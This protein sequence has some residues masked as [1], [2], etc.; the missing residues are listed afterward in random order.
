MGLGKK[1]FLIV[2]CNIAVTLFVA[3]MGLWEVRQLEHDI[4]SILTTSHSLRNHME[5]DMMHDALRGDVLRA[6]YLSSSKD[7]RIGNQKEVLADI[8]EHSDH[9]KEMIALNQTLDLSTSTRAKLTAT[10]TALNTYIASA[11]RIATVAFQDY[12]TAIELLPQFNSAFSDLEEK[13]GALSDDLTNDG[14]FAESGSE[15]TV[16]RAN[17]AMPIA[18]AIA[19]FIGVVFLFLTNKTVTAV[20]KSVSARMESLSS[21]LF[22]SSDQVSASAQSLA[23]GASEQAASLQETAATVEQVSSMAKHNAANAQQANILSLTVTNSSQQGVH[24]MKEMRTAIDAIQA[25]SDETA[26]IIRTID[27]IAFQ[28]NLLAL[29]AAVEAA[30]AGEAGKGFAVVAEEVR[31]LA[32]RSAAAA[33]ETSA[34]IQRSKELSENGVRVSLAVEKS[35][36]EIRANSTKALDIVKEIAAASDE[37][38]TGLGQL[39]IAM[40]E[41]DKVTQTNAA[42]AEQSSAAGVELADQA[43]LLNNAVLAL[44]QIIQGQANPATTSSATSHQ[45]TKRISS[46]SGKFAAPPRRT[47]SVQTPMRTI[48]ASRGSQKVVPVGED[49]FQMN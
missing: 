5:G 40:S 42:S 28:T 32:Q 22:S 30:R 39:N 38:S 20:L 9:F 21:Q 23:Q 16:A 49:D 45:A 27:E 43:H 6:L 13:L 3:G 47:A 48:S 37:Q 33:K 24:S 36:E 34:K 29:N 7:E 14:V 25:A 41:L 35:L 12:N 19:L 1:L 2:F 26:N 18:I 46:K 11:D 15:K 31:N 44:S 4:G 10:L 17:V 8:K